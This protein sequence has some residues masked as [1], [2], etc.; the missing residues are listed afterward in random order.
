MVTERLEHSGSSGPTTLD[1]EASSSTLSLSLLDGTGFPTG[2]VGKFVVTL[3]RGSISEERVLCTSRSG[4]T[5][6]VSERGWDGTV[7]RAHSAGTLVEHTFSATEADQANAHSS[8]STGVHGAVGAVVGT[9][10]AQTLTNKTLA[11]PV[12]ADFTNAAHDHGD[13]DDGGNIPQAS[14]TSLVSDLAAKAA[15]TYV[16]AADAVLAAADAAHDADTSPH[17]LAGDIVGTTDTQTLSNKTLTTPTINVPT[18]G[19]FTNAAHDHR[20]ADSGGAVYTNP[21]F[22]VAGGAISRILASGQPGPKVVATVTTGGPGLYLAIA[23]FRGFDTDGTFVRI[24]YNVTSSNADQVDSCRIYQGHQDTV[25]RGGA[26]VMG[27]V[28]FDG[29]G[30]AN[31]TVD[32]TAEWISGSGTATVA[33]FASIFLV[34]IGDFGMAI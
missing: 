33:A 7:A 11:A 31:C 9:T 12:I 27:Y 5:L 26:T 22:T 14:V 19:D 18:I 20:D 1:A 8:A 2:A 24:A 21:Q 34:R 30:S 6:T 29:V 28:K 10:D 16:D 15:T 3:E 13:V 32:A 4:G 17:G 23:S 25:V